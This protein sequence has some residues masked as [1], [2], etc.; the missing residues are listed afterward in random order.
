[1]S[2]ERNIFF[3]FEPDDALPIA[4]CVSIPITAA[5]RAEDAAK[6]A[7]RRVVITWAPR[8]SDPKPPTK[9]K[10]HLPTKT[11]R[12]RNQD[13]GQRRG[14]QRARTQRW[15]EAG[16]CVKCGKRKPCASERKTR[17]PASRCAVCSE[18]HRAIGNKSYAS[19]KARKV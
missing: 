8:L 6:L 1:M 16:M 2:P 17:K 13:P 9:P 12:K 11:P 14:W 3:S 10:S 4:P 18:K 15:R 7:A 5:I 19:K